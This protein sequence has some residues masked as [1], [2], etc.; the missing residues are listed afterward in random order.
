MMCIFGVLTQG[1]VWTQSCAVGTKADFWKVGEEAIIRSGDLGSTEH[2]AEEDLNALHEKAIKRTRLQ[3]STNKEG[4]HKVRGGGC[5][6]YDLEDE[7]N[8][9]AL[10][11]AI[12]RRK[13][14]FG[15]H[16]WGDSKFVLWSFSS[17]P[18]VDRIRRDLRG[19]PLFFESN[20][21]YDTEY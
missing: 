9:D 14:K 6:K 1:S 18:S 2:M 21:S 11:D 15:D 7:D 8:D 19:L 4:I 17:V 10:I 3:T 5:E 16:V 12:F 13:P 20:M